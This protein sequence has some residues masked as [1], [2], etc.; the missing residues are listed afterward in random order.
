MNNN[1]PRGYG[2]VTKLEA[3]QEGSSLAQGEEEAM[4]RKPNMEHRVKAQAPRETRAMVRMPAG[5]SEVERSSP[6]SAPPNAAK[7]RR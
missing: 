1:R 3:M 6:T 2:F 7:R 4:A 5:W